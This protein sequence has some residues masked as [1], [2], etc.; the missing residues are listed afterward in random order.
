MFGQQCLIL[1]YY[2]SYEQQWVRGSI[3]KT[4]GLTVLEDIHRTALLALLA[5]QDAITTECV[6]ETLLLDVHRLEAARTE[7]FYLS[8]SLS[9]LATIRHSFAMTRDAANLAVFNSA[10]DFF[11]KGADLGVEETIEALTLIVSSSTLDQEAINGLQCRLRCCVDPE[12]EVHKVVVRRVSIFWSRSMQFG[13]IPDDK[14]IL[15]P[16]EGLAPRIAQAALKLQH[17]AQVNIA[18]HQEHY[19]KIL[20]ASG[21]Q[22]AK[23]VQTAQTVQVKQEQ[24]KFPTKMKTGGAP[25]IKK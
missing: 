13:C 2:K 10:L 14:K 21:I 11:V 9:M 5:R 4:D 22:L 19:L 1:I 20:T 3:V 12:D 16:A 24:L 18:V 25:Q 8:R 23:N 17:M 7:F 6:P 15:S